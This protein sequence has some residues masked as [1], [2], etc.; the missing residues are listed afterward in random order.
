MPLSPE[1]LGRNRL[2][3]RRRGRL[4]D[5]HRR[6]HD[7]RVCDDGV[8]ERLRLLGLVRLAPL[9]LGCHRRHPNHPSEDRTG[10]PESVRNWLILVLR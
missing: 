8:L 7:H 1:E 2:V 6:H 5:C 4:D 10:K 9:N 3:L